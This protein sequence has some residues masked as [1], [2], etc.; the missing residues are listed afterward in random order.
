MKLLVNVARYGRVPTLGERYGVSASVRGSEALRPEIAVAGDIGVRF[1]APVL[2]VEVFAFVRRAEDLIAYVRSAPGYIVPYNVGR[3]ALRGGEAYATFSPWQFLKIDAAVTLL[4]AR[5]ES[6]ARSTVNDVLP[7]RSR[8]IVAPRISLE[9]PGWRAVKVGR[10][11]IAAS[12]VHQSNRY[13]DAA[14]LVV[15]PEQGNM[16]IEAMTEVASSHL[17][18]RARMANVLDQPRFDLVGFP[19]P[20]RALYAAMEV[21]W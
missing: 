21:Q 16:D 5:D 7:F 2:D 1:H 19:L 15:I 13:A 8:L 4:D 14:G 11:T 17:R 18:L 6:P 20:G 12:Y 3:A 9:A 10:S